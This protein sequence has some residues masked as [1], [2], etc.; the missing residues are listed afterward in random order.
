M[1]YRSPNVFPVSGSSTARRRARY[2]SDCFAIEAR[3]G[4]APAFAILQTAPCL[5]GYRAVKL[6]AEPGIEPG[7]RGF[8]D[9]NANRYT[10]R[11]TQDLAVGRGIE[12][13]GACKRLLRFERS[14][15][16]VR[17]PT[18]SKW[19]RGRSPSRKPL[20]RRAGEASAA[21]SHGRGGRL[22][23][24]EFPS[25]Y[26]FGGRREARTPTGFRP[27]RFSKPARRTCIRL[28][29]VVPVPGAAPG[30]RSAPPLYRRLGS[31]GSQST[32]VGSRGWY[33]T[34]ASAFRAP[35]PPI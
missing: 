15:S 28:P 12:P 27:D 17:T 20:A 9:R 18:L 30:V 16:S 31:L 14:S 23:Y 19:R 2:R 32:G 3:A 22:A 24:F 5:L 6:A 34:T 1:G 7:P 35:R 21:G 26:G 33:R 11:P 10:P 4:F 13:P 25:R 29:S 8:G